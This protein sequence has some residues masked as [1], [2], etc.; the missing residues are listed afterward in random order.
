MTTG[1]HKVVV[2]AWDTSGVYGDQTLNLTVTNKP[3]VAVST[4]TIGSN[5][6][7]PINIHASATGSNGQSIA[8]WR[9]Y[10][11]GVTAY[12][13]SAVGAINA[14]V[15]ASAGPHTLLVRAWD[16]SGAYG[17]QSLSVQVK[18]VA[19]N[20]NIPTNGVSVASPVNVVATALSANP[21]TGWRVYIDSLSSFNQSGGNQLDINLGPASGTHTVLV[22]AWDTTGSYG[23]QTITV[24]VP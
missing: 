4:P 8:G 13:A 5:V 24:T 3:A 12:Q 23:D 2:R 18:T 21:I 7:S 19:V 9:V 10:L 14:S 16:S 11:D 22:R 1:T 20:I 6:V 17:D 15:S